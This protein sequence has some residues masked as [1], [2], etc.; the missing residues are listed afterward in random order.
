[1]I[2]FQSGPPLPPEQ[3]PDLTPETQ[4]YGIFLP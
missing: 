3:R 1:M 4:E 2:P